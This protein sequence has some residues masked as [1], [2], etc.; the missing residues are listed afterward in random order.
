LKPKSEKPEPA[1]MKIP[2]MDQNQDWSCA[3]H[4]KLTEMVEV[5]SSPSGHISFCPPQRGVGW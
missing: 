4:L 3:L 1:N 5:L 2:N